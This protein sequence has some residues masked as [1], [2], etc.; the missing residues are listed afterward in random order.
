MAK[1]KSLAEISGKVGYLDRDGIGYR[2]TR[3]T[4]V[5]AA[6][7]AYMQSRQDAK[8]MRVLAKLR[9]FN[10]D[11]ERLVPNDLEIVMSRFNAKATAAICGEFRFVRG[12]GNIRCLGTRSGHCDLCGKGDSRDDGA[13]EDKLL[14]E[15]K[16]TNTKGGTDVWT[17]STCIWQHGLHVDGAAN[18]DEAKEILR[19][20][21]QSHIKVWKV[22]QWQADNPDHEGIPEFW[23]LFRELRFKSY[24]RPESFWR[25]IDMD[26][27]VLIDE[28]RKQFK[29]MRSCEK[30]YTRKT[31]L[32]GSKTEHWRATAA[33]YESFSWAFPI[34]REA[35]GKMDH[36]K[37]WQER[38]KPAIDFITEKFEARLDAI[39][40]AKKSRSKV[41]RSKAAKS[42][43]VA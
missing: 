39:S 33:F 43:R 20:E 28:W 36:T 24:D 23:D 7:S 40:R 15:F 38:E 19:K 11:L 21:L 31:F 9:K 30:F 4:C 26:V 17:G 13:N 5:L 8:L 10:F 18:A 29:G 27:W 3:A 32:S 37:P 34:F 25:A 42:K 1:Q 16:L 12:H 14:Y 2:K 41:K 35:R 6:A 22:E